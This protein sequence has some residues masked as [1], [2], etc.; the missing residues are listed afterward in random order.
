LKVEIILGG[1]SDCDLLKKGEPEMFPSLYIWCLK[2]KEKK[3]KGT[4]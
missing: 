3:E 2:G 1:F 4:N